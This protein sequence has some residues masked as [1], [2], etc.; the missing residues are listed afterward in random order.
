LEI[1]KE[2]AMIGIDAGALFPEID[3]AAAQIVENY[4]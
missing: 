3:R 1:R 4:T 2:L